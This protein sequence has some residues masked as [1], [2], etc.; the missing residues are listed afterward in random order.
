MQDIYIL[1]AACVFLAGF[2]Y[3]GETEPEVLR[4][5]V[6]SIELGAVNFQ[7][8][9]VNLTRETIDLVSHASV[10]ERFNAIEQK[11]HPEDITGYGKGTGGFG[12]KSIELTEDDGGGAKLGF[13][14]VIK[15]ELFVKTEN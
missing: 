9:V 1:G 13:M 6:Q 5:A 15:S 12:E 14:P 10:E 2:I 11:H 7:K 8:E 4:Q 3:F